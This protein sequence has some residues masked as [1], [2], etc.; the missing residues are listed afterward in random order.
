MKKFVVYAALAA[1][2]APAAGAQESVVSGKPSVF[3]ITPYV[4]YV[5]YGD[6]LEFTDGTEFT[7]D[8]AAIFGGQVG[9]DMTRYASLIG[10]FGYSKTSFEFE[11]GTNEARIDG[12]GIFLYD[13]NLHLKAPVFMGMTAFSPFVQGGVGAMK[14]SEDTD[15]IRGSG[16]T[17]IA[18][19][20]GVGA[21][22]QIRGLGIRLMAK[23]YISSLEWPDLKSSP[24]GSFQNFQ[25]V[26][27][28]SIAH[29]W[30]FSL[31]L[32]IGF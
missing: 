28:K 14:F 7:N 2:I 13:A 3:H 24:T 25:N 4:G 22:W 9:L 29:N 8:N 10:N 27:D 15:D 5:A 31:G 18:Y 23:D 11:R 21:D 16:P 20:V 32:K 17:N 1:A 30:A 26:E 19:N 12:V 6:L